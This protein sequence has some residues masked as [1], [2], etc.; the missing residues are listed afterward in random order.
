MGPIIPR[1]IKL[2]TALEV[3]GDF[4]RLHM[5][6]NI[7]SSERNKIHKSCSWKHR[8]HEL[9]KLTSRIVYPHFSRGTRITSTTLDGR[10][11]IK[12][13]T[14]GG[15]KADEKL[16]CCKRLTGHISHL[17]RLCHLIRIHLCHCKVKCQSMHIWAAP[18]E[19]V[20]SGKCENQRPRSVCAYA[21]SD[22]GIRCALTESMKRFG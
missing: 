11:K 8:T 15:K 1:K 18:G 17:L 7:S 21:Q 22:R 6:L 2:L 16:K 3:R 5:A 19:N 12:N 14:K 4:L 13:L 10:K 9:E 20:S